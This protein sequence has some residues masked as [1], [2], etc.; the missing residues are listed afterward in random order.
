MKTPI[1]LFSICALTVVALG[2]GAGPARRDAA[3][4][5]APTA[6]DAIAPVAV[7]AAP[8][9]AALRVMPSLTVVPSA[10]ERL[11]AAAL[12]A[13]ATGTSVMLEAAVD[14]AKVAIAAPVSAALPRARLGNPFYDFGRTRRTAAATE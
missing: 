14:Q 13:P 9:T 11:A 10:E 6:V 3:P 5:A 1:A 4:L 12:D 2:L 7:L 8:R